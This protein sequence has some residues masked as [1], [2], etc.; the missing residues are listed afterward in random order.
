LQRK[1]IVTDGDT[2]LRS[3]I[4]LEL[5][6][7]VLGVPLLV[8]YKMLTGRINVKHLLAD[9][10][11]GAL[12][13]SRVQLLA[14]TVAGALAYIALAAESDGYLPELDPNLLLI[15]GGSNSIYLA[16]KA[17][18]FRNLKKWG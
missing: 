18:L 17:Q 10:E 4:E 16:T 12:S 2:M 1:A 3:M 6:L 5:W 7:F 15:I 14:L 11:T 8:T 9:K 13:A